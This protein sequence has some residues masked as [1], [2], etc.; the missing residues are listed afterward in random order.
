MMH[1]TNREQYIQDVEAQ[2]NGFQFLSLDFLVD[3][4]GTKFLL[5]GIEMRK[6]HNFNIQLQTNFL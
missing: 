4:S 2:N 5:P 1:K 6:T 3:S